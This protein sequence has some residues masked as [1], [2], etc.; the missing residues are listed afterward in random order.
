MIICPF[1]DH[2]NMEG[3]DAC[4]HCTQSLAHLSL[5][6]PVTDIER[7]LLT[8][9]M[10]VLDLDPVLVLK[11]NEPVGR[12][13]ALMIQHRIGCVP[14]VDDQGKL[15]GI[16]TERDALN[17]VGA[18]AAEVAESPLSEFMTA[19]PLTLP[20]TAKIAFAVHRMDLGGFRHVPIVDAEKRPQHV[21]SARD[22]LQYL[23]KQL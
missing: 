9:R 11:S 23:T 18:K 1:C 13:I 8:D 10:D 14:V 16:F 4:E 20:A 6:T 22:I 21:V 15:V 3:A 12:A 5:P 19:T 2:A 17:R 7:N